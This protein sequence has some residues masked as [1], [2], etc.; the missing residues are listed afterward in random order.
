MASTDILTQVPVNT[1]DG[2]S[3]SSSTRLLSKL[4]RSPTSSRNHRTSP[5][6]NST[7]S[8]T[9]SDHLP[10]IPQTSH[11]QRN[12][13]RPDILRNTS[14]PAAP[15]TLNLP[16]DTTLSRTYS[17][18]AGQTTTQSN[19]RML[20]VST[21]NLRP[22]GSSSSKMSISTGLSDGATPQLPTLLQG[23]NLLFQQFCD[24]TN[25]RMGTLDYLRKS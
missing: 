18:G 12:H 16:K 20:E 21:A 5:S 22:P 1:K 23:T 4:T 10:S 24:I 19:A 3:G 9:V 11:S 7:G 17:D 13:I 6:V 15:P 14:A 25:K 8:D 2:S